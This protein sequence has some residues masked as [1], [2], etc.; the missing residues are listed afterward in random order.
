M[1]THLTRTSQ[2]VKIVESFVSLV[3]AFTITIDSFHLYFNWACIRH[4]QACQQSSTFIQ[5]DSKHF[6]LLFAPSPFSS[7]FFFH[8]HYHHLLA[9]QLCSWY[10]HCVP[11]L[12]LMATRPFFRFFTIFISGGNFNIFF[13][14]FCSQTR[15]NQHRVIV[16]AK[17]ETERETARRRKKNV[18]L[19]KHINSISYS[20]HVVST[21]LRILLCRCC[22]LAR[23]YL[24]LL[25]IIIKRRDIHNVYICMTSEHWVEEHFRQS[26]C[27]S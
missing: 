18:F 3:V 7:C 13:P 22:V 25:I 1:L 21:V 20:E 10:C 14:S 9:I 11:I 23:V 27:L 15:N 2:W 19:N 5:F 26:L 24:L 17:G 16:R 8:H 12:P 4:P 6:L